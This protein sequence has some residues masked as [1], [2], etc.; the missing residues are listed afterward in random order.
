MYHL[1]RICGWGVT[2]QVNQASNHF[3]TTTQ[4]DGRLFVSVQNG[5]DG[6]GAFVCWKWR[7]S[8]ILILRLRLSSVE[9]RSNRRLWMEE[10]H[11]IRFV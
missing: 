4:S 6:L 7:N 8:L 11:T 9:H 5:P 3:N 1:L 10:Y 2:L